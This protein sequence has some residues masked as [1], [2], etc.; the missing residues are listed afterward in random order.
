MSN[1]IIN[2][3][4]VKE[5]LLYPRLNELY[6]I[7]LE[8]Q[9]NSKNDRGIV[10]YKCGYK[11]ETTGHLF[12]SEQSFFDLIRDDESETFQ[13]QIEEIKKDLFGEKA[14]AYNN[15]EVIAELKKRSKDVS[16]YLIDYDDFYS[17][18]RHKDGILYYVFN[19]IKYTNFKDTKMY[20]EGHEE[21]EGMFYYQPVDF[22]PGKEPKFLSKGYSSEVRA[23]FVVSQVASDIIEYL[24]K[25]ADKDNKKIELRTAGDNDIPKEIYYK[26]PYPFK[27][28]NE[29]YFEY[30]KTFMSNLRFEI[31]IVL[32]NK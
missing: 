12:Y 30:D 4:Y 20:K 2:K 28:S 17:S 11:F 27:Y 23:K 6:N 15:C 7:L 32:S 3:E 1:I 21:K 26:N 31:G 29:Q 9:Y 14:H 18:D 24:S 19:Y 22:K 5:K 8:N 13:E 10:S 16:E 25:L